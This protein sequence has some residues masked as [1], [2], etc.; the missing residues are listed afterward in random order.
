MDVQVRQPGARHPHIVLASR[1][2]CVLLTAVVMAGCGGDEGERADEPTTASTQPAAVQGSLDL[3]RDAPGSPDAGTEAGHRGGATAT[4]DG[5]SFTFTGTAKPAEARVTVRGADARVDHR[6]NG[7]FAVTLSG[8]RP[9]LNKV[10]V[11]ATAPRHEPW[12]ETV[13]VTRR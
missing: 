8:L 11:R 9:G 2:I 4:A 12:T 10:T 3:E 5:P 1:V 13:A 6:R 7:V